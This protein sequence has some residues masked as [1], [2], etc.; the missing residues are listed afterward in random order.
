M[1]SALEAGKRESCDQVPIPRGVTAPRPVTTTLRIAFYDDLDDVS[2]KLRVEMLEEETRMG[3][4][5]TN[6]RVGIF[7]SLR[8]KSKVRYSTHG[9]CFKIKNIK[10]GSRFKRLVRFV[11][12]S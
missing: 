7:Y 11:Q 6:H 1:R 9:V 12:A 2:M 5:Q 3:T 10:V 8:S 4:D